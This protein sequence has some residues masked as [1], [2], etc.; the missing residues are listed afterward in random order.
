[1]TICYNTLNHFQPM[2]V[3]RNVK[4]LSFTVFTVLVGC[5][6]WYYLLPLYLKDLGATD[7]Q[8][9]FLYTL[10]ALSFTLLQLIGGYFSDKIGRKRCIVW[11]TYICATFYLLMGLVR[12]W[13]AVALFYLIGN[14][15]SAFQMPAFT[16]LIS[17]SAEEKGRAFSFSETFV[18]FGIATG[19][20]LG[21]LT[22]DL[23]GIRR[24]ILITAFVT[25]LSA[26]FRHLLI[27]EPP[28]PPSHHEDDRLILK[29]L[30]LPY[31]MFLIFGSFMFLVFSLTSNGPFLT[32]F[33]NEVFNLSKKTINFYFAAGTYISAFSSLILADLPDR[34]GA[35]RI[36]AVCIVLLPVFI[37][38]WSYTGKAIFFLT[39]LPFVHWSYITYQVVLTELSPPSKRGTGIGL[40]GTITGL[41]GSIGPVV[42]MNLKLT[43]GP[44]APFYLALFLSSVSLI[45]LYFSKQRNQTS[46]KSV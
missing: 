5:Y 27:I 20:L 36:L 35:K 2:R 9:G 33:G 37:L 23:L 13:K 1:M 15:A 4:T 28:S 40:Y 3:N 46:E 30:G 24:L 19:P 29:D 16:A 32:L 10:F 7:P 25:F 38:L 44:R 45:F 17:E 26:L 12:T 31:V 8:V 43:Y 41:V 18:A 6:S 21:G 11:P 39:A 22:I 34:L 14:L 42:G